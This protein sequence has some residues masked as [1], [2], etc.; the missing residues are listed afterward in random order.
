MPLVPGVLS[1]V[2]QFGWHDP[3]TLRWRSRLPSDPEFQETEL[4][5]EIA[6]TLSGILAKEGSVYVLDH[7]FAFPDRTGPIERFTLELS[8]DPAWRPREQ[9][10]GS[11]QR[12]GL[13]P[14]EGVVLRIPLAY[15]GTGRP[16]A[17]SIRASRSV[18]I[19]LFALLSLATVLLYF[20]FRSREGALGRF[21]PLASPD[22]ID[23]AWLDE[24]LLSLAPEEA[25]A[26]WDEKIGPPEVAAV[27]ARLAA[28][29]KIQTGV[30]GKKLTMRRLVGRK[31]FR[32]YDRELV[33]ALFFNDRE[34]TDTDAIRSHYKK[35][36]FDPASKI[37]PSLEQKLK[38]HP[39]F[40]DRSTRP[41][42]WPALV[43]FLLRSD[44]PRPR[45]RGRGGEKPGPVVGIGITYLRSCTGWAFS[46]PTSFRS[47]SSGRRVFDPGSLGSG[48]HPLLRVGDLQ[49]DGRGLLLFDRCPA[50]AARDHH[51]RLQRRDDAQRAPK[52]SRAARPSPR[53]A[54]S[55]R[56][57]SRRPQPR[58]KDDGSPTSSHSA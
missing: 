2:D 34:E 4:V 50:P 29:K 39:D 13:V 22:A 7:D 25:G 28:E 27:L 23:E 30:S 42:R 17:G 14:G 56:A 8:L 47:E 52:G 12:R 26:L 54:P 55:S 24:N 41:S 38:T 11:L 20:R 15:A 58:L 33:D 40:Q 3:V 16:V 6:Y 18:R 21:A 44:P 45:G 5:Y 31:D 43:L 57:S 46:S 37:R 48:S 1:A 32:E 9:F 19:G 35:S 10:S 51:G 53:R 36:G 49:A